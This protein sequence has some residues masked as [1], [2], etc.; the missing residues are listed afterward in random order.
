MVSR[1]R[2][3]IL[4]LLPHAGRLPPGSRDLYVLQRTATEYLPTSLDAYLALPGNYA[5]AFVLPGGKTALEALREQLALLETKVR[6][7]SD[8]LRQRDSERLLVHGRFLE[9][10]FARQS[11]DLGLPGTDR[12]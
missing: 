6:E 7:I 1:I 8:A 12:L 5:T 11:G 10:A 2:W 4:E 3:S 9:L